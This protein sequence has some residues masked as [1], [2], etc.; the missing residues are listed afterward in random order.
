V[1]HLGELPAEEDGAVPDVDERRCD[2]DYGGRQL[3][4]GIYDA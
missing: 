1:C 2:E 3:R 4:L